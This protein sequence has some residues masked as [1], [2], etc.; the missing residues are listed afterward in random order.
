M[1]K[2]LDI[3]FKDLL[4]TFRDPAALVLLLVTPFALTLVIGF[5]F[6]GLGGD[7]G[8]GLADI[9]VV[10]VNQDEGDLGDYL[11][12][13]F[14]SDDLADL[15]EPVTV[16]DSDQARAMVD[17]DQ[18]AAAVIVPDDFSDR[19]IP[20]G[21]MGEQADPVQVEVYANPTRSIS[22]GV[23]RAIVS[24]FMARVETVVAATG[25]TVEQLVRGR[26]IGFSD[27]ESAAEDVAIEAEQVSA[28][29]PIGIVGQTTEQNDTGGF[30]WAAYMVPS[31]AVLFLMFNVT[32]GGRSILAERDEGTLPRL[33]VAPT[34]VWQVLAGKM[35][36]IY[37]TGL[38]QLGILISA[39][40]WLFG[41]SWGA[42]GALVGLLLVLV[43]AATGWGILLAAYART[44][45]Q[46]SALGTM[47]ALV[48]G[49]M[50]G[51]FVPRQAMPQWLQ[52]I[53]LISP[54]AWGLEGFAVLTSGGGWAELV[55]P[56]VALMVMSVVLFVAALLAFQ[57][58]YER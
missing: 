44:P 35:L 20:E 11:V 12:E 37:L 39:T 50:A 33:L 38:A 21:V 2:I 10:I 1:K 32:S 8:D 40:S 57:R 17:D 5:A 26:L 28:S 43:L 19:L 53:S 46:V 30:N 4:V 27:I 3:A 9:P 54:N 56:L 36:G 48:F 31:M 42:P 6:G 45:G 22:V 58:Q 49:A 14:E 51:N 34:Q 23:V 7:G 41:V 13:I 29:A 15:V 25:V 47:L 55:W 52:T 24:E 16:E 18:A